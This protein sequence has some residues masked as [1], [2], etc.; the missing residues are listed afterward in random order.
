MAV[1][2]VSKGTASAT[3][4]TGTGPPANITPT[5]PASIA[6]NDICIAMCLVGAISNSVCGR[7]GC[8]SD[9]EEIAQFAFLTGSSRIGQIGWFWKRMS[10]GESGT[11]T[12]STTFTMTSSV[13]H[14]FHGN[15]YRLTGCP[16]TGVPWLGLATNGT[17]TGTT[18]TYNAIFTNQSADITL[19]AFV[20]QLDDTPG[21]STPSTYSATV[22][23]DTN[24]TNFDTQLAVF[25]K[26]GAT[27]T[28]STTSANGE[29]AGWGALHMAF[30]SSAQAEVSP[31]AFRGQASH[32]TSGTT[33]S[34]S[35]T[36]TIPV[37]ALAVATGVSDNTATASGETTEH[38][39]TD[40][41]GNTW[42]RLIEAARANGAAADGVTGSVWL[43]KV[44][45]QIGTSDTVTLTLGTARDAKAIGLYRA[46]VHPGR[47]F[48]LVDN[49]FATG[50]SSSP[51]VSSGDIGAGDWL[52][53][54][55]CAIEGGP[56]ASTTTSQGAF[57]PQGGFVNSVADGLL[58]ATTG[59]SGT[60]NVRI[61]AG[62][63]YQQN[64]S[65]TTYSTTLG[66]SA[67]WAQLVAWLQSASD[68]P[69]GGTRRN[70]TLL[71]VS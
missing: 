11:I 31:L 45:T 43:T 60:N 17:L 34:V 49:N 44:T 55:G 68:T 25:D 41:V 20:G 5:L 32:E 39:V 57:F 54:T 35:P 7:I 67:D 16:T 3:G 62:S 59:L 50:S 24:T 70:L 19:L 2:L 9:W 64:V 18:I 38:T 51:S 28:G 61:A 48:T 36:I 12:F 22:A 26:T 66:A 71:G 14:T 21:A 53:L 13:E 6:A 37:G 10:G 52:F 65:S 30:H 8:P 15:I 40:S 29:S 23:I 1:A 33:V 56:P 58:A 47:T 63:I 46:L 69:G 4:G 42:T 27:T